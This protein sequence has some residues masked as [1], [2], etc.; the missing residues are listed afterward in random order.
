MTRIRFQR[1]T[2]NPIE[3]V[4]QTIDKDI[5]S[6]KER[7]HLYKSKKE[8]I[9][10]DDKKE[11]LE[12]KKTTTKKSLYQKPILLEQDIWD[13]IFPA[14]IEN[15][16]NNAIQLMMGVV[17]INK[18]FKQSN[19][20]IVKKS[21]YKVFKKIFESFWPLMDNSS[22]VQLKIRR[23]EEIPEHILKISRCLK[24][25]LNTFADSNFQFSQRSY[26]SDNCLVCGKPIDD[27]R[28]AINIPAEDGMLDIIHRSCKIEPIITQ[29]ENYIKNNAIE[30]LKNRKKTEEDIK[31]F[32]RKSEE[33]LLQDDMEIENIGL[34]AWYNKKHKKTD[35][36]NM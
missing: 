4:P 30:I 15:V 24:N 7:L 18:S 19:I 2:L 25:D 34:E 3:H 31:E 5:K 32:W 11:V 16:T 6:I 14:D 17:D 26:H 36:F 12:Q 9:I 35:D 10:I 23:Q 13:D 22:G 27:I 29:Y 28:T 20:N 33:E 1:N 21:N 8:D